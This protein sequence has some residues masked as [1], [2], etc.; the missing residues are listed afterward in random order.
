MRRRG[1]YGID[2]A[3]RDVIERAVSAHAFR[4]L[5]VEWRE[6]AGATL[7]VVDPVRHPLRVWRRRSDA[8][9]GYSAAARALGVAVFT[10]GPMMGKRVWPGVKV[11]RA[12][13][14][15]ELAGALLAGRML[16]GP[17]GALLG[18][19]MSA[20]RSFRHWEP[21][22]FVAGAG[23]G[24]A[25]RRSF[26]GESAR[27][28]WIGRTGLPFGTYAVGCGDLPEDVVEGLGGLLLLVAGGRVVSG[29]GAGADLDAL[30]A[31]SGVAAWGLV[32]LGEGELSANGSGA[33]ARPAGVLAVLGSPRMTAATAAGVL[34]GLGTDAAVGTDQ[35][36]A[37]MLGL[38]G[39][40]VIRPPWHRQAMQ[41]YGLCC[42]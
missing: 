26:D 11:T 10:N 4:Q 7:A 35:R 37:V 22:G 40:C 25:R 24:C 42:G 30:G 19:A 15:C 5:G 38:G 32:P 3:G 39:T 34:A 9:T 21:C 14:A 20:A 12:L 2:E 8:P 29:S 1:A 13:V 17:P 27:H 36:G 41:D 6:V 23:E 33:G 16:G 31:K 18:G 28:G